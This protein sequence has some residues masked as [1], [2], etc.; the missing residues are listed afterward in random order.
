MEIE[1]YSLHVTKMIDN[2]R[3]QISRIV[4]YIRQGIRVKRLRD[5]ETDEVSSIWMDIGLPHSKKFTLGGIYREHAHLGID[6]L[7]DHISGLPAQQEERWKEVVHQW[8][9]A[10]DGEKEV[11]L[12]GDFNIDVKENKRMTPMHAKLFEPIRCEILSRGVAQL[13]KKETR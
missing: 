6:Q 13:I 8:G 11:T 7:P 10:L 5:I 4:A 1:G 12:I 9:E 2:P 3:R